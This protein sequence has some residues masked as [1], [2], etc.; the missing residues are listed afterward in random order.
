[1][2]DPREASV[3]A[4]EMQSLR[5]DRAFY[6][7]SRGV[8]ALTG[9]GNVEVLIT[10][11]Q[12]LMGN[13]LEPLMTKGVLCHRVSERGEVLS[14]H[15][16]IPHEGALLIDCAKNQLQEAV[17]AIAKCVESE[18]CSVSD[19]SDQWR[20][21][22]ELPDQST[23]DNGAPFLKC[24]DPRWH[25]GARILRPA[26]LPESYAWGSEKKW[27][28]HAMKLGFLP[29]TGL[30]SMVNVS[31]SL[32]VVELGLHALGLVD[33]GRLNSDLQEVLKAPQKLISRRLLPLRLEP[34]SKVFSAM[35]GHTVT[36]GDV[37]LGNVIL[38]E[39]LYGLVL[40][41]LEPWRAAQ[42]AGQVLRCCDQTVLITWP[43]WLAQESRGR[44]GPDA[45]A[46]QP[47]R[48]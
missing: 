28:G 19:V 42:A 7:R 44:G 37:E 12:A 35:A 11:L 20:V 5:Q 22:G 8:I 29:S 16:V 48:L 4:T 47:R 1:M 41:H 27:A 23:F 6:L 15:F 45:M 30:L 26:S 32:T 25:M 17:A 21:F 34:N 38:H 13:S 33:S 14:D 43:S 39:G 3:S 2:S 24:V 18:G 10:S 46:D 36:A 9:S 40:V 31:P